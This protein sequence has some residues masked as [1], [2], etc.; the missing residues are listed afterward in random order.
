MMLFLSTDTCVP[1]PSFFSLLLISSPFF[2]F[3]FFFFSFLLL[4]ISSLSL[5]DVPAHM[6]RIRSVQ[7]GQLGVLV[8]LFGAIESPNH[9]P[10]YEVVSTET[11]LDP[12]DLRVTRY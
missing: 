11:G 2:F 1:P 4:L 3:F 9:V 7:P 6:N 10:V 5:R 12:M 8:V